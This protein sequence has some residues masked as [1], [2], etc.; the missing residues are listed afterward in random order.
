MSVRPVSTSGNVPLKIIW[1]ISTAS[2]GVTAYLRNNALSTWGWRAAVAVLIRNGNQ[3]LVEE[4]IALTRDLQPR[5]CHL[6][7]AIVAQD[8]Y[9][10]TAG[11]C[12]D[13]DDLPVTGQIR[14]PESRA[15]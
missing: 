12:I 1:L 9:L 5:S 2:S 13:A 3:P 14:S 15:P 8:L 4:R 7:I 11:G 6:R 10:T